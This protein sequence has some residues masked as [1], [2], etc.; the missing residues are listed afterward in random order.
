MDFTTTPGGDTCYWT[1]PTPDQT[2]YGYDLYYEDY[3]HLQYF[4]FGQQ[5]TDY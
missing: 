5:F 3:I 2:T 1:K 4:P